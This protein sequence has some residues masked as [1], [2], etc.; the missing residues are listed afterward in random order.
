[1]NLITNINVKRANL[2]T[3]ATNLPVEVIGDSGAVFS[4]QVSR[5]SD[6][7]FY[8]FTTQTFAAT[9][10]SQ[11]R[12]Y[13]QSPGAF[14]LAIPAAASGD[15]YTIIIM[16]EPHYGTRLSMGNGIR[17]STV[18]TQ[19]G[20]ATIT[21]AVTGTN[22]TNTSIG[23][24]VGSK[25]NSFST[26]TN[27]TVVMRDLLLTVPDSVA[28]YGFF[29]TKTNKD[30]DKNNGT[31]NSGALYW[32]TSENI[33]TNPAGDGVSGNT[34]TV[35]DLTGLVVGMEL[36][37]HK[38]TTTPSSTTTIS[39]INTDTKTIT[40]STSSAFENGETMTFRAYGPRIIKNAIG[41]GLS[42]TNPTVKLGQLTTTLDDEITSNVT[43]D[44]YFNVN[45]TLGIGK[46]ATMRMRGLEKSEDAGAATIVGVNSSANGGGITGGTIAVE[47]AKIKA[48]ADRP[49][50]VL[51]KIY[52]DGSSNLVYLSG[53][54]SI[55]KYPEANQNIYVDASKILTLGTAS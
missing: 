25:L 32:T 38:G 37:Y 9:V 12:L 20:N 31:W 19:V 48:S 24:S 52:I 1:M 16:A 39:S 23:S 55:S 53:T 33:V 28:D 50:R 2:A 6:S 27:P 34:V 5:S 47:N 8:N 14:N 46:G 18:I 22:I 40:F 41:I 7:R 11:S 44:T 17:Y 3:E 36:T 15:T 26:S 49:I 10:T 42:L 13:N 35:A 4:V 21:F 54:I 30:L 45:G 29:I 43:T 51:T